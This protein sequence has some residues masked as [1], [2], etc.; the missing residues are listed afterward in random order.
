MGT[1]NA[2]ST[3]GGKAKDTSKTATKA[4][5]AGTKTKKTV[6]RKKPTSTSKSSGASS[7]QATYSAARTAQVGLAGQRNAA[8]ARLSDPLW[9]RIEDVLPATAEETTMP[10]QGTK[11]LPEQVQIVERALS[12]NNMARPDVTPQAFCVLLEQARR[13][14]LELIADAQDYAVCASRNEI[15]KADLEL[16]SQM[17]PDHPTAVTTQLPKLNLLAQQINR[18]PLPPIP[19]QCYSGVL[20]PP[21]RH[22][23]TARTYDVVSGAQVAER[24]LQPKPSIATKRPMSTTGGKAAPRPSYGAARGRQISINLKEKE[25]EKKEVP[26]STPAS[27]PATTDSTPASATAPAPMEISSPTAAGGGT[28]APA[29]AHPGAGIGPA[30]AP[31]TAYPDPGSAPSPAPSSATGASTPAPVPGTAAGAAAPTPV[32][33]PTAAPPSSDPTPSAASPPSGGPTPSTGNQNNG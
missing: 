33:A 18:V 3:E 8:A 9:Y 16:A 1:S 17:R 27:A 4:S 10:M 2:A 5:G 32:S 25:P 30:P 20:L 26:S 31:G 21:K 14:A 12:N 15:A 19:T 11:V 22:Q 6:R 29:P 28:P 7:N 13:Y 23:L 24:M